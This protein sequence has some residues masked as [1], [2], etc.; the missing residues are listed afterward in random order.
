M[1]WA[2]TTGTTGTNTDTY[3]LVANLRGHT[4]YKKKENL[5]K[6]YN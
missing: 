2:G 6:V 4:F 1:V 3:E 5:V